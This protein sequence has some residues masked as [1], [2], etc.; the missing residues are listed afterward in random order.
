ML[1]S[2]S[3]I[4]ILMIVCAAAM[5][6][7]QPT[8]PLLI[9]QATVNKTHI[10]FSY[11]GDIWLVEKSGGRAARLTTDP[12]EEDFPRFSPDG[13]WIA[14]S[15]VAG[16][17]T[18]VF[19]MP[20]AGGEAKRLTWYPKRDVVMGWTPDSR[21]ILFLS[22]RDE[23]AA[24]RLYTISMDG[25]M[26]TELPLPQSHNGSFSPDGARIAYT[27]FDSTMVDWP[28]QTDRLKRFHSGRTMTAIRCGSRTGFIFSRTGRRLTTCSSTTQRRS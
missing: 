15:R 3:V 8:A 26:P 21:S 14:F 16:G 12:A 9:N 27:P 6:Q 20:A 22:G 25:V 7:E 5:A 13:R 4:F 1:K 18:D 11:A 2:I 10:A 19:V 28:F 23:E 17:D 24:S